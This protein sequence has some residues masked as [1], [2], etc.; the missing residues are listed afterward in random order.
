[1]TTTEA[2][3]PMDIPEKTKQSPRTANQTA[4]QEETR[5]EASDIT[6]ILKSSGHRVHVYSNGIILGVRLEA[7]PGT[8]SVHVDIAHV[9][10]LRS[11][12]VWKTTTAMMAAVLGLVN[13][14][15]QS[16]LEDIGLEESLKEK[17]LTMPW[18]RIRLSTLLAQSGKTSSIAIETRWAYVIYNE[19]RPKADPSWLTDTKRVLSITDFALSRQSDIRASAAKLRTIIA[20][21]KTSMI[22]G[23]VGNGWY[24][25]LALVASLGGL[26]TASAIGLTHPTGMAI[27]LVFAG[28][29]GAVAIDLLFTSRKRFKELVSVLKTEN[30]RA[31]EVGDSVRAKESATQNRDLLE[32]LEDLTF[33]VS[34]LMVMAAEALQAG[35]VDRAVSSAS[36]VLDECVRL[37]PYSGDNVEP[38]L[39]GPDEGLRRFLGLMKRLGATSEEENL[40]VAYVGLTG[41]LSSPIEFSEVV[42]HMTSLTST[43]YDVGVLSQAAKDK[44]DNVMNTWAMKKYAGEL[45]QSLREPDEPEPVPS[46]TEAEVGT[47]PEL[48]HPVARKRQTDRQGDVKQAIGLIRDSPTT[49]ED[50]PPAEK[51]K[52]PVV[53]P[54][55]ESLDRTDPMKSTGRD[56]RGPCEKGGEVVKVTIRKRDNRITQ[57]QSQKPLAEAVV[58]QPASGHAAKGEES[59]EDP[60]V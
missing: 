38:I 33:V 1:M 60:D 36:C 53:S 35:E 42:A 18:G 25:V 22:R 5:R 40:A 2:D 31:S 43:L 9:V 26:M 50:S 59:N 41:H 4:A 54:M 46:S 52:T 17:L 32:L 24:G 29:A 10:D 58:G 27:P 14:S 39:G 30:L 20:T 16:I 51:V 12:K 55:Q 23:A 15:L 3:T 56:D 49:P 47:Q 48:T 6:A 28:V 8:H 44:L 21:N 34:P 13:K 19:V 11:G 45:E 7:I 57:L 37:A